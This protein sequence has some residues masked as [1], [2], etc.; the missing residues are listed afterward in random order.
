MSGQG[1]DMRHLEDRVGKIE[2][3]MQSI[4]VTSAETVVVL[5]NVVD[6]VRELKTSNKEVAT[7]RT[8]IELLK[9][10]WAWTKGILVLFAIPLT[11]LLLRSFL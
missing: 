1:D 9:H 6:V 10:N 11:F 7:L 2:E 4:A 3:A 5:R 8:S